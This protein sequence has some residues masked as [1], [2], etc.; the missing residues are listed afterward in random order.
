M[1]VQ[2]KEN[3]ITKIGGGGSGS[4][5]NGDKGAIKTSLIGYTIVDTILFQG[6]DDA[7]PGNHSPFPGKSATS[8]PNTELDVN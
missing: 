6:T 3:A 1:V 7:V 2:Y 5:S 8:G 4:V